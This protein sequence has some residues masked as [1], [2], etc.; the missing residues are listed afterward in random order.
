[1]FTLWNIW[2]P[3]LGRCLALDT[4]AKVGTIRVIEK[5]DAPNELFW[6][7]VVVPKPNEEVRICGDFIQLNKAVLRENHP[8]PITEQT[9]GK[10]AGARVISKLDTNSGFLQRKLKDSSKLLTTFITPWGRYCYTPL[11][12]GISSA[13]QHFQKSMQRILE[14]LPGVECQM[15]DKI[16][17]GRT[18]Q[19]TTKG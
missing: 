16:V 1:M 7:I 4:V 6:P 17:Y 5:V 8:M 2:R 11:P 10:L 13:P 19:N 15:D 12:F 3:L 9:L 14:D 18:K